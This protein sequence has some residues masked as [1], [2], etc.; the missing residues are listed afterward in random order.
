MGIVGI[1]FSY[2][3]SNLLGSTEVGEP[4]GKHFENNIN[5]G[6]WE[7]FRK[8]VLKKYVLFEQI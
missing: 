3:Y 2:K 7:N 8:Y 1:D 4:N 6:V 5:S